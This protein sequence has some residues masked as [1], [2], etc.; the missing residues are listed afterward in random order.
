VTTRAKLVRM[1]ARA[2]LAWAAVAAYCGL[3]WFLS[4]LSVLAISIDSFPLRDKGI[5]FCEYAVLAALLT[6][7]FAETFPRMSTFHRANLGACIAIAYGA[8]DEIHQAFVPGRASEVLDL[9]AD[10]LGAISGA[11]FVTLALA[12]ARRTRG[13]A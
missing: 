8:L 6:L 5:H 2:K 10:S 7:A 13:T 1:N 9:V 3:I 11:T 12:F 4:S